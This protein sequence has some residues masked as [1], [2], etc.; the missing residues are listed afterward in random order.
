MSARPAAGREVR[1]V[2]G[3]FTRTVRG[4]TLDLSWYIEEGLPAHPKRGVG[5]SERLEMTENVPA[6]REAGKRVYMRP[7]RPWGQMTTAEKRSFAEDFSRA[8]RSTMRPAR[9]AEGEGAEAS[10]SV[11]RGR[12]AEDGGH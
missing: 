2:A 8:V 3:R 11:A 1:R 7:A 12:E 10:D 4:W 5:R 6:G 9:G